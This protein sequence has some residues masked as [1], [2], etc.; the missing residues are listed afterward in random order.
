MSNRQLAVLFV[1]SLVIWGIGNGLLPLLPV[2]ARQ[3]GASP[4]LVGYYLSLSYM[5]LALGTLAAGWLSDTFQKRKRLIF[6]ANAALIP[7]IWLMG[8]V[9][10]PWQLIGLTSMVWFTAGISLTLY[11]ILAGLFAAAEERGRVFGILALTSGLGALIGGMTFGGIADRWGFPALFLALGAT[12]GVGLAAGAF[13]VDKPKAPRRT[14]ATGAGTLPLGRGFYLLIGAS[15]ASGT[16]VFL[17]RLATSLMMSELGFLSASIAGTAAV[18]GLVALPLAPLLGRLSD[19]YNRET[20]LIGCY[21]AGALGLLVLAVSS[22]LSHFWLSAALLSVNIYVGTGIASALAADLVPKESVG[23]GIALFTAATWMGGIVGFALAG[24]AVQSFGARNTLFTA[25][26]FLLAS[27]SLLVS[28]G[29]LRKLPVGAPMVPVE[30]PGD[31][32]ALP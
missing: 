12:A 25:A 9:S 23:R 32:P 8:R 20:V 4:A 29:R 16:M 31:E 3:I 7:G 1:C 27:I 10:T 2:Y 22:S 30:Q 13:L 5:A 21:A 26:G 18:G 19:R 28:I 24:S 14:A 6:I 17:G 11:G 15:L